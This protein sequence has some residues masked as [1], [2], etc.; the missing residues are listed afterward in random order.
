MTRRTWAVGL[1][2][3]PL[4]VVAPMS[5]VPAGSVPG[6]KPAPLAISQ[7]LVAAFGP[8]AAV[9]DS[10]TTQCMGTPAIPLAYRTDRIILRP[11][12]TMSIADAVNRV[13]TALN[14]EMGP[15]TFG[16]GTPDTVTWDPPPVA[17]TPTP[18]HAAARASSPTDDQPSSWRVVAVPVTSLVDHDVPVVKV[19][20]RLRAGGLTASP[21]YLLW[22]GD[23]PLGVWPE[24]PPVPTTGPGD[25]RTGLGDGTMVA[26]YDTGVPDPSAANLPTRLT[27]LTSG[28][29]EVPDRDGDGYA[30][31]YYAVHLTAIAGIFATVVPDA[32]VVGVRIMGANGVAT[33]FSAAKRM[34]NTLRGANV[35]PQVIVNSF[36]SPACDVGPADPGAEMVPLGL[37]LVAEAVDQK[38]QAVI[39]AAAGNLATD[40]PFYP[41]AFQDEFPA[42]VSVGALD[43]TTDADGDPWTSASRS[44]APATFSNYGSW[45]TAWAPGVSLPT[46]HAVGL[47]FG[48][49]GALING[50]ADV[51]GTSFAA[52]VVGAYVLEQIARTGQTPQEAWDAVRG[53]GRACSAAI[54]GGVAVALTSETDTSTTPAPRSLPTEC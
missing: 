19:A 23:G 6:P 35:W 40:R 22:P 44:A 50:Y 18:V 21:D 25:P 36:G 9:D 54:G 41:A 4:A 42:M 52:P 1:L 7:A 43:A 33:D 45:V 15:G 5:A 37:Q 14:Y 10:S 12:P 48:A 51:N 29:V 24:G 28:D 11:P 30:D 26:V 49:N 27:R 34:V 46:Y 20:R 8:G 17:P 32:S 16:V 47:R 39:V 53:S 13:V 3:A 38:Q 2:L 31:L